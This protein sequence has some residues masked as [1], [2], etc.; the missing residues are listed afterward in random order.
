MPSAATQTNPMQTMTFKRGNFSIETR[1]MPNKTQNSMMTRNITRMVIASTFIS[2][3]GQL[4]FSSIYIVQTAGFNSANLREA[5]SY[6]A[7]LIML[8][9]GLDFF[10]Y[11]FF[12]KLF[13][14]VLD[15]YIKKICCC[16]GKTENSN[17]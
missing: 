10:S 4:P 1:V 5:N 7:F 14:N 9:P 15:R 17:A 13:K 8:S 3:F 6:A 11:Y 12:N 16:F 2:V